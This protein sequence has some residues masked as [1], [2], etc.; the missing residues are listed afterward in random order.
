MLLS[1]FWI[2]ITKALYSIMTLWGRRLFFIFLHT[3]SFSFKKKRLQFR[4]FFFFSEISSLLI[5]CQLCFLHYSTTYRQIDS[6]C[7]ALCGCKNYLRMLFFFFK[8]KEIL[9]S[10]VRA[11][12]WGK[13]LELGRWKQQDDT[14]NCRTKMFVT[15]ALYD[16]RITT[17]D[18]LQGKRTSKR[19]W[20]H[21]EVRNAYIIFVLQRILPLSCLRVLV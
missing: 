12:F 10:A 11:E 5:I 16:I 17:I 3:G 4:E 20:M 15:C 6:S 21:S 19:S 13:F 7:V 8:K 1:L 2:R 18:K 9:F 14:E